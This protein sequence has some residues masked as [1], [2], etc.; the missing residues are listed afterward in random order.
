MLQEGHVKPTVDGG[1]SRQD[2][3]HQLQA[4]VGVLQV[5]EHGL[6]AVGPLGILTEAG[7]AL[8]GHPSITRDLTQL[9][10]E[11]PG[12]KMFSKKLLLKQVYKN[13]LCCV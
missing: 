2:D 7:L 4:L 10:G 5:L 11:R 9:V 3:D 8:D 12:G 6:H 13:L 1:L